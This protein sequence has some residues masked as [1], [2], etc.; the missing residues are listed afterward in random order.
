MWLKGVVGGQSVTASSSTPRSQTFPHF[1]LAGVLHAAVNSRWPEIAVG[2]K[3]ALI[4]FLLFVSV[5]WKTRCWFPAVFL[6]H[7]SPCSALVLCGVGL[8]L[9]SACDMLK[10]HLFLL[11]LS[12]RCEA[13]IN[14]DV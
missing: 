8:G 14:A 11:H 6:D 4:S 9:C 2:M 10:A 5:C 1:F 12:I 13:A 3:E 7:C